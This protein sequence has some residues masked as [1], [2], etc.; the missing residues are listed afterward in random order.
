MAA[1]LL[2]AAVSFVLGGRPAAGAAVDNDAV[3]G[4][5]RLGPGNQ[6]PPGIV[7]PLVGAPVEPGWVPSVPPAPFG[8]SS[9]PSPAGPVEVRHPS[10]PAP[11]RLAPVH[12]QPSSG[13]VNPPD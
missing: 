5:F 12:L 1:A 3:P 6:Q 8:A 7:K 10:A 11:L 4:E 13:V 2:V 9:P